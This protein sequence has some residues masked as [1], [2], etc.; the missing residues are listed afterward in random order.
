MGS[1]LRSGSSMFEDRA[2]ITPVRF[3]FWWRCRF[4]CRFLAK[5]AIWHNDEQ[6]IKYSENKEKPPDSIRIRWRNIVC[7]FHFLMPTFSAIV[8]M[9]FSKKSN[10]FIRKFPKTRKSIILSS[11]ELRFHTGR[12]SVLHT[13]PYYSNPA[14]IH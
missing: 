11:P 7:S 2:G 5:G 1:V 10:N 4:L 13:L 3:V 8:P 6:Y 12:P 14:T 9:E